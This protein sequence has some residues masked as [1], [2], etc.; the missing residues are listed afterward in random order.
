MESLA[1]SVRFARVEDAPGIARIYIDAW[2]DT[3]PAILSKRLLC[4]MTPKGQSARWRAVIKAQAREQVLVAESV[5]HGVIGMASLGPARDKG[6]GF[7]GEV[8]TLYVDPAHFGRGVGRVLLKGT[9]AAL[10]ARGFSS[11]VIWAHALNPARF[12]YEALGGRLVAERST[13]M[14]GDPVPEVAFGWNKLALAERS[15]TSSP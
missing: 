15:K 9:F 11:C 14:M 6:T 12:F 2:H 5:V 13:C 8:Y 10:R 7:D 3:Y 1:L 4:A